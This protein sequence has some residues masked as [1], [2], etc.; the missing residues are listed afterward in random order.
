[1]QLRM[2][3][4][5]SVNKVE[6]RTELWGILPL[7]ENEKEDGPSRSTEMKRSEWKLDMS[8][9]KGENPKEKTIG[10]KLKQEPW[11]SWW[12]FEKM[13]MKFHMFQEMKIAKVSKILDNN[14]TENYRTIISRFRMATLLKDRLEICVIPIPRD[15]GV[16]RE[17][18]KR[19]H[20]PLPTSWRNNKKDLTCLRGVW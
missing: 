17:R 15:M 20:L 11:N 14:T 10:Y 9:Q 1:M 13:E 4:M 5:K 16:L 12:W 7:T 2:S 3:L 6:D 18:G 8:K 19:G